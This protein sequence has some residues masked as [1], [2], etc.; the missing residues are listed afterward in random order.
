MS[1]PQK[2]HLTEDNK[3]ISTREAL[4]EAVLEL[5]KVKSFDNISLRE[6]TRTAGISPAAFYRHFDNMEQLGLTI[7]HESFELLRIGFKEARS[8]RDSRDG[9][10]SLEIIRDFHTNYPARFRF[11]IAE[12]NGVEPIRQAIYAQWQILEEDLI[13]DLRTFEGLEHLSRE[14]HRMI[15]SVIKSVI[16]NSA[17]EQFL[18]SSSEEEQQAAFHLSVSQLRLVMIGARLWKD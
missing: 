16:V 5:V 10:R 15:A 6:V 12:V 1:R 9:L 4:V 3:L 17:S 13:D 7:V 14:S 18:H 8:P 2:L 11:I